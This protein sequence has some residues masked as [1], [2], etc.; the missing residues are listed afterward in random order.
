[1]S[2][3]DGAAS[4]N[5][6]YTELEEDLR[7]SLRKLLRD[8]CDPTVV[9]ARCEQ[10]QPYD[11]D[12]WRA[13]AADLGVVG[14]LIPER[15]GGSGASARE[16][17]VFAEEAGRAITPLPLLGSV[18]AIA[19][20]LECA[21]TPGVPEVLRALADGSSIAT[22]AIPMTAT[23]GDDFPRLVRAENNRLTGTVTAVVDL[24]TADTAVVPAS[25]VD[26]PALYLLDTSTEGVRR[27]Q[28]TPL[29][30]TRRFG[31]LELDSAAATR[32][33]CDAPTAL[34]RA[35]LTA[36]GILASEQVGL[37]QYCLDS[38]VD[39]ARTRSQF[40]RAIGSFQAVKHRLADL[41]A[42]V[43]TARAVA[44]NAADRLARFDDETSLAVA[45]AQAYCSDLVVLAAEEA[46]QLHGGIAM[47]WEHPAHLALGRAKST[48]LTFGIPERHRAQLGA[49]VD[50]PSS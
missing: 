26:G 39:Y 14:L 17:A 8:R 16:L 42:G 45:L 9:V 47:T 40:G 11:L 23:A 49:L 20:L 34:R 38:T 4:A 33:S 37:A 5:L 19:A 46:I 21:D 43:S 31:K 2:A 1:V 6:L 36:A 27:T 24:H 29:D 28:A 44:R 13:L 22:C 25:D 10:E 32:L 41:W 35:L 7:T 12:L 48:Q 3:P 50:L 18:L 30:L 15:F